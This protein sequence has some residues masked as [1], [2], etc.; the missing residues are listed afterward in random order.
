M[1]QHLIAL[2]S[3]SFPALGAPQLLVAEDHLPR[4]LFDSRPQ[5]AYE[6]RTLHKHVALRF[7][8]LL[9]RHSK[10]W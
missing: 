5:C 4:S 10:N 3:R 2:K 9:V 6:R 1:T 8:P 7:L